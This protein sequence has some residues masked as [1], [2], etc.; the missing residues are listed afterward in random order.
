VFIRNPYQAMIAGELREGIL[1]GVLKGG[2]PLRQT[3]IAERF[4]VSRIL[5][6]EALR[7]LEGEGL[8]SFYPHPGMVVSEL[9]YEEA[10]EISEIRVALETMTIR[11]V[12]PLLFRR[13][14]RTCR[15]GVRHYR[16]RRRPSLPLRRAALAF[17][18]HPLRTREP[19]A[20][21][22]SDKGPA[23]RIRPLH[24]RSPYPHR[25]H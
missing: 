24:P 14:T 2:Q 12:I 3:E 4:R 9:S 17:S 13:G 8:I 16:P 7:Q 5:V 22:R 19:P 1:S 15:G 18:R 6:R 23:R 25:L 10:R 21:P 11:K 20:P